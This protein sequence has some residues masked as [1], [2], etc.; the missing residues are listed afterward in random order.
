M[1]LCSL[2]NI[3]QEGLYYRKKRDRGLLFSNEIRKAKLLASLAT[4][5]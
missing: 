1:E 4:K 2:S 5:A 3:S